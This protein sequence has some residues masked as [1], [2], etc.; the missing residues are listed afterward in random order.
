MHDAYNPS[1]P[2]KKEIIDL[3]K[4]TWET[5]FVS[6]REG[7]YPIIERKISCLEIDHTDGIGTKGFYHWREGTLKN[8]VIDA[9]AM[10]LN[11]LAIS[12]ARAFKL[13]N[14]ITVPV[15][16][17]RIIE[18]I[19]AV[20]EESKKRNIAVTGGENSFHDN[21]DSMDISMTVS[22]FVYEPRK[23]EFKLEDILIG[24][25]SGG[26][27][28]NGFTL[29]RKVFGD[30]SRG[31][32]VEPT[33]V[34]S[35]AILG[36]LGKFEIH[37]ME[38]IT[39]GAFSKLTRYSENKNILIFRDHELKPQDIFCDIYRKGISDKQMYETLKFS[40]GIG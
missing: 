16:D 23:N 15:E 25:S 21:S 37:G 33:I 30:L 36:L 26:I 22:G 17:E 9:L 18:I 4:E 31:E 3:I 12:G 1:K 10:N 5:P 35:D 6:V 20:V 19:K 11:D 13:Q 34:Y 8:A 40:R 29:V 38:H 14:H 2:Y 27:H 39:G 32:F 7:I 28:S 24:I